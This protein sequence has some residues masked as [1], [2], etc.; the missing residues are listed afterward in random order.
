MGTPW[1][2]TAADMPAAAYV[3]VFGRIHKE[4]SGMFPKRSPDA[5]RRTFRSDL[6][7]RC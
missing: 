1:D 7:L 6:P 4:K 5:E 2:V 3:A